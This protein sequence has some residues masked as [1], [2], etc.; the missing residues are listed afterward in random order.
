MTPLTIILFLAI[1]LVH[2]LLLAPRQTAELYLFN[3]GKTGFAPTLGSAI[4]GN[5]GIGTFVP[6]YLFASEAPLIAYALSLT[7]AA[8]LL[9]CAWLAPR[10]HR[11]TRQAGHYGLIDYLRERHGISNRLLIWLPFGI[12][13]GLRS[14]VQILAL[15]LILQMV[16]DLS[17]AAAMVLAVASVAGYAV[18]GGYQAATQTDMVQALILVAG[19][20]LIAGVLIFNPGEGRVDAPSA[21]STGS[22]GIV[23]LVAVLLLFPFST[24]LSV[25]N[26]QRIATADSAKNARLAYVLA[27]IICGLVNLTIA[28][29]GHYNIQPADAAPVTVMR[30]LRDAMPSGWGW[31]S[32]AVLLVAVMSSIDTFTM[33]VIGGLVGKTKDLRRARLATLCY[34]LSLGV[35]ALVMGD[36]LLN[37]IAAFSSLVVFLPAVF[38]ALFLRD[39][40]PKA[41]LWSTGLGVGL[42]LF[43]TPVVPSLAALSGFGLSLAIYLALRGQSGKGH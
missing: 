2:A 18:C 17:A 19:I 27:A 40:A 3:G 26:W 30:G 14:L 42:T 39:R 13:F 22:Y 37:V 41:V 12:V 38:G 32:D 33:P 4:A 29:L 25:D 24:V 5:I 43:L 16:L 7:Y 1:P 34:F 10:I 6:L 35:L 15:S 20:A 11:E 21:L 8:G 31:L 23:F 36:L 9:L 28:Y